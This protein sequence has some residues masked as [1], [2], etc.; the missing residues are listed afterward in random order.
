[1][2]HTDRKS[3]VLL[4]KHRDETHAAGNQARLSLVS[5]PLSVIPQLSHHVRDPGRGT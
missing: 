5:P 2:A 1:M 4:C 3:G